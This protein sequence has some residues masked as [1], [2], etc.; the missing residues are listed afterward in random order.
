MSGAEYD[1]EFTSLTSA[2]DGVV[3][4]LGGP[5]V[6]SASLSGVF[7]QWREVVGDAIADHADPIAIDDGRLVVA[8]DQPGWATQL[9]F[10]E[11]DLVARIG[12][13]VG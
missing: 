8:V 7:G 13:R 5:A 3:R 11:A 1:G 6:S 2:L 12:E 9:R 4:E 10:L